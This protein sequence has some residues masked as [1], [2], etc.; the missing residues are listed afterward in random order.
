MI[1]QEADDSMGLEKGMDS[2]LM[3]VMLL[4]RLSK[5]LRRLSWKKYLI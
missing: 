2:K 5:M 1:R 4:F 3:D